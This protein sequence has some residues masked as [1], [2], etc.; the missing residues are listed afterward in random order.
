VN[1]RHAYHAGNFADVMKHAILARLLLNLTRKDAAFFVLDTHA[2]RGVYDLSAEAPGRTLEWKAGI[3]RIDASPLADPAAERLL[4]PYR[5]ALAEVRLRHGESAC[6]GSPLVARQFLRRQDRCLAIELHPQD[7]KALARLFSSDAR[8]KALHLDGWTALHANIPPRER[9]GLVLI[10]PPYEAEGELT[11]LAAEL[12]KAWTKWP[13]GQFA[14]WYPV[15]DVGPID[16]FAGGL[17][18]SPMRKVLRLDLMIDD[19]GDATRLNGCGLVVV[20]PPF[21]L[22]DEA[23]ILLPALAKRLARGAGAG[24]RCEQVVGE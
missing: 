9:R 23:N 8:V 15:K 7:Y 13:T 1:Y 5:A 12:V 22:A 19:A 20:N 18:A 6:P 14:A 10:D 2:G 3:G 16:R 4:E 21:T 24:Y 17:A 11:R